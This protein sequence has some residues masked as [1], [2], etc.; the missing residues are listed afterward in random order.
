M[1]KQVLG[2]TSA[3][4]FMVSDRASNVE[5]DAWEKLG[6]KGWASQNISESTTTDAYLQALTELGIYVPLY[7]KS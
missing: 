5:Y 2:G 1:G 7:E 3:L 4:N 6:N